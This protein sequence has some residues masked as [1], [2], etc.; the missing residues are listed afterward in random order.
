MLQ[1]AASRSG[2]VS[3]FARLPGIGLDAGR[4]QAILSAL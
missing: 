4:E 1:D 3:D 2:T